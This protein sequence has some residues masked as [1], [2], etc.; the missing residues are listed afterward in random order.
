MLSDPGKG[1]ENLLALSL[2]RMATRFTETGLGIFEVM[3]IRD[4]EK[5]EVDFVLIKDNQPLALLE[6][7]DGDAEISSSGK[8][9]SQ[10][11]GIPFYRATQRFSKI[12]EY[13]GNSFKIRAPN[14]L[15]LTG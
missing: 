13:P 15:M 5:R 12:E 11:P 2:L 3:Y 10:K 9:F 4:K 6:A 14:F 8:Y 1:F 7:T